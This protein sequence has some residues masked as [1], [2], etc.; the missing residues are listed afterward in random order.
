ML[1]HLL[2]SKEILEKTGIS[3]ASL[4]NYIAR[5]LLPKPATAASAAGSPGVRHAGQFEPTVIDTITRIL[6]LKQSGFSLDEIGSQLAP[7]DAPTPASLSMV[8]LADA[9]NRNALRLTIEQGPHMAYLLNHRF[10]LQ[11]LND[12]ARAGMPGLGQP[13]PSDAT[14]R[15]IFNLLLNSDG[16]PDADHT[17][18]L[19]MNLTLAKTMMPCAAPPQPPHALRPERKRLFEQ[20]RDE[21]MLAPSLSVSPGSVMR[22]GLRLGSNADNPADSEFIVHATRFREGIFVILSLGG[23]DP[24]DAS[25]LQRLFARRDLVLHALLNIQQP[26]Q[27]EISV[28]AA[29]LQDAAKICSE[30]PSG[31]YFE[32]VTQMWTLVEEVFRTHGG[33]C[34]RNADDSMVAYF[35]PRLG[36][37]YQMN[38]VRC[39]L[40]LQTAMA[41]FSMTWQLRKQW[42]NQL[43]LNIGLNEAEEWMGARY[44]TSGKEMIV[45]G[46][47]VK[48]A[49][50]LSDIAQFGQI[51]APKTFIAKMP[52]AS[53][54]RLDFGIKR[55][56]SDGQH[57]LVQTRYATVDSLFGNDAKRLAALRDIAGIELTEI[58][59]V[60]E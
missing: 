41:R 34:T 58:L 42:G 37:D 43:Y 26:L 23:G 18:A 27:S 19:R 1:R 53:R 7:N 56:T 3:R 57:V 28:V 22:L 4:H 55:I 36:A 21:L 14:G 12:A 2:T 59:G 25:E 47:I 31:E 39:A 10:E 30:L 35:F 8:N 15:S 51:W 13:L 40:A 32:L 24:A 49:G 5:G 44:G 17:A 20:Y 16:E 11:W 45:L 52:L 48:H 6:Q 54:E 50:H 46:D 60:H 33:A 29:R 38:A 9:C